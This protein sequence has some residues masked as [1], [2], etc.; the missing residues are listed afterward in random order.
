[1]T[2]VSITIRTAGERD[3]SAL[4]DYVAAL[5]AERLP[6]IFRYDSVPTIEEETS[7]IRQ[8]AGE[9]ADFFVAVAGER[10]VGNLAVAAHPHPQTAHGASLGMSML[11]PYR[12]RGIGS[13][14]LDAAIDWARQRSIRRLELEV[15]S[16]NPGA[17][18][19]YERK[20]FMIEGCRRGAVAVD[21]TFV[22]ALAMALVL[23]EVSK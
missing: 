22:D 17:R 14:L 10:I 18:R 20:G 12:G 11:A 1:M 16:N 2:R 19:L 21:G 23:E 4:I 8:F 5:R 6:T 13:R 3:V 7:F 9:S 15:L